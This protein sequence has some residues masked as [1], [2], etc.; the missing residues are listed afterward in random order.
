M[1][2]SERIDDKCT[3]DD[4]L[5]GFGVAIVG[6]IDLELIGEVKAQLESP[7]VKQ[8]HHR[9][10]E[11]RWNSAC[12]AIVR[13]FETRLKPNLTPLCAKSCQ[14][15]RFVYF[16][17]FP[18]ASGTYK[19]EH[20]AGKHTVAIVIRDGLGLPLIYK[21][22]HKSNELDPSTLGTPFTKSSGEGSVI[23][24]NANM[25]QKDVVVTGVGWAGI[26]LVY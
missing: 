8:R 4:E 12:D 18:T 5:T 25:M 6:D 19:P 22:S 14:N 1:S 20:S 9:Q 16:H 23:V 7:D 3:I 24:F 15:R 21:G 2:D 10:T 17:E 11:L 26:L 13:D